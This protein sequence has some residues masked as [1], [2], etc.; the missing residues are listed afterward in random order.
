MSTDDENEMNEKMKILI[1]VVVV[2]HLGYNSFNI[3]HVIMD[4]VVGWN[5]RVIHTMT[6]V[7]DHRLK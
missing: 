5:D 6:A 7:D 4:L 2:V 1:I 3:F